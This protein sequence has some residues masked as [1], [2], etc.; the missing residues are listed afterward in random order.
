MF[1]KKEKRPTESLQSHVIYSKVSF[2]FSHQL[3]LFV[4]G[5]IPQLLRLIQVQFVEEVHLFRTASQW[6]YEAGE[7]SRCNLHRAPQVGGL[8]I[9]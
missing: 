6:Q 4:L 1:A 5:N 7:A 2:C 9:F 8:W 3:N